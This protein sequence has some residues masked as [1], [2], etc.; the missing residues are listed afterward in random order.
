MATVTTIAGSATRGFH[1]GLGTAAKFKHLTGLVI[2]STGN[3]IVVDSGNQRI[4]KI[5][6]NGAVSTMVHNTSSDFI[7]AAIDSADNIYVCDRS[8]RQSICKISPSGQVTTLAG[9]NGAGD[10]D[11]HAAAAQFRNPSGIAVDAAGNVFVADSDNHKIRKISPEGLVTTLAGSGDQD[12]IDGVGSAAAFDLPS[13]VAVDA[14]GNVFVADSGNH[15]IRKI[16][17]DGHVSTLAGNAVDGDEDGVGSAAQFDIPLGVAVDPAG[18]VFVADP[19]NSR[20][21]KITPDGHVTTLAGDGSFAYQDGVGLATS[22]V[23]PRS[24]AIDSSGNLLV[25]D[26]FA[27]RRL[28]AVASLPLPPPDPATLSSY[29]ADMAALL[30]DTTLSDVQFAVGDERI[31]GHRTV[32]AIRSPYVSARTTHHALCTSLTLHSPSL[33][34]SLCPFPLTNP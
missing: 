5:P 3:I 12:R 28:E 17:P 23:Y 4:R 32:L 19:A 33:R 11:S 14:A 29:A 27:V 18:N 8:S 20:I 6:P 34:L 10:A 30:D 25:A 15:C 31:S 24:V 16:S 1:D 13:A 7:G 9:G 2:D 26:R 22:F 21:R